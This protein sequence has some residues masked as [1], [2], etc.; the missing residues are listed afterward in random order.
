MTPDRFKE[1]LDI[2]GYSTA[3]IADLCGR[4]DDRRVRRWGTGQRQIP[5]AVA[6]WL[7]G[8]VAYF[9]AH[10]PPQ[11]VQLPGSAIEEEV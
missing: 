8:L 6:D 4:S 3:Q 11:P 1:C 9:E 2:L 5:Y 10:P 7:E